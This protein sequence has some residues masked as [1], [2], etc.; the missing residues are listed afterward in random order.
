MN[1]CGVSRLD[2]LRFRGEDSRWRRWVS[3]PDKRPGRAHIG[4]SDGGGAVIPPYGHSVPLD[5]AADLG[6]DAIGEC[7]WGDCD[8]W[9]W[10]VRWDG[11]TGQYLTVCEH[12]RHTYDPSLASLRAASMQAQFEH[13]RAA[14]DQ[15]LVSLPAPVRALFRI[16]GPY[17]LRLPWRRRS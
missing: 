17:G 6:I 10:G 13:L 2:D 8:R 14:F 9:P 12:C 7:D 3:E 5:L 1:G 15:L 11:E 16:V 4:P